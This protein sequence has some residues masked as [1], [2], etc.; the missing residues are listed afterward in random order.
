MDKKLAAKKAMLE[1]MSKN[2]REDSK[3]SFGDELKSKKMSKVSVI[4]PDDKS[5]AKG[6]SK[7]QELIKAKFGEAGLS[8]DEMSED[9]EYEDC[10]ICEGEGCEECE[11]EE[12]EE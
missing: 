12:V 9:E 7:A 2:L 6:L 4:A 10:P 5:L 1:R 8:E 3:K 11:M